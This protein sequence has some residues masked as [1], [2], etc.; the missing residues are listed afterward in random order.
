MIEDR[1]PR[2]PWTCRHRNGRSAQAGEEEWEATATGRRAIFRRTVAQARRLQV[3]ARTGRTVRAGAPWSSQAPVVS[4]RAGVRA[5]V[6][7]TDGRWEMGA[8]VDLRS[9]GDTRPVAVRFDVQDSCPWGEA[10]KACGTFPVWMSLGLA[11]RAAPGT[12]SCSAPRWRSARRGRLGQTPRHVHG[13][14]P[15][16]ARSARVAGACGQWVRSTTARTIGDR[17][18]TRDRAGSLRWR[19]SWA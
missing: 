13:V 9:G 11:C 16:C 7:A 8:V 15:N 5:P 10:A 2:S 19:A 12:S 1:T 6:G 18:R 14:I 4:A 3:L 17:E